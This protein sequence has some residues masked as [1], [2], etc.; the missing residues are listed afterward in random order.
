[1]QVLPSS[2][3]VRIF[4]PLLFRQRFFK[5]TE[6]I[7]FCQMRTLSA[8]Q[9]VK[10]KKLTN[11]IPHGRQTQG[12][13]STWTSY[14]ICPKAHNFLKGDL[15]KCF[16]LTSMRPNHPFWQISSVMPPTV[17]QS[18]F[19]KHT[20]RPIHT[21]LRIFSNDQNNSNENKDVGT[22]TALGKIPDSERLNLIF[23]CKV[24]D[25]RSM[26]SISRIGY[27]KGVVI[28][29]CPG[30][31][32]NHLIADNLGWFADAGARNIE[33]ILAARGETVK[34]T[35]DEGDVLEL[36]QLESDKK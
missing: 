3:I 28:V 24:C 31:N 8:P 22:K 10:P 11:T 14:S 16:G 20:M 26:K 30:C 35:I 32:K 27:E 4:S 1:M 23:T 19:G 18:S 9:P 6:E 25:T 36:T 17:D 13:A 2:T 21:G 15:F 12:Y 33:E 5:F 34:R 7:C 29:K